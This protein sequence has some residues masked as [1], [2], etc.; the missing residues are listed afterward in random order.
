[1]TKPTD[2]RITHLSP[3]KSEGQWNATLSRKTHQVARVSWTLLGAPPEL[4][5]FDV[6]EPRVIRMFVDQEGPFDAECTPE[7]KRFFDMVDEELDGVSDLQAWQ[8][9]LLQLADDH[10]ERREIESLI[11]DGWLVFRLKDT[12]EG[13]YLTRKL[14]KPWG[15]EFLRRLEEEFGDQL[16]DVMNARYSRTKGLLDRGINR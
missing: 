7:E 12:P 5:W 2:Y 6:S 3:G 11:S 1:M 9:F 14:D 15:P 4:R 13:E 16:E 10:Q 8:K